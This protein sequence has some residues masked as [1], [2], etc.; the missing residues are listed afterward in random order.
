MTSA[1]YSIFEFNKIAPRSFDSNKTKFLS[2]GCAYI[3]WYSNLFMTFGSQA[4]KT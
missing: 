4:A 3:T 1:C 2:D